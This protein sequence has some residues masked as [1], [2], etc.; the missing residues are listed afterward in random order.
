MNRVAAVATMV[1]G[2][3]VLAE[4][5]ARSAV[6]TQPATEARQLRATQPSTRD[7]TAM[8]SFEIVLAA[9]PHDE[10][11]REGEVQ[12]AVAEALSLRNAG[13]MDEALATLAHARTYVP[14]DPKLLMDFGIQADS[15]RIYRDAEAA[16][17]QAHKLAPNDPKILYGLAHVELDEQKMPQA[18][19]DL[20]AYLKMRPNDASAHYGL[21]HLLH[22]EIRDDEAKLEFK[23]SLDLEP[24]QTESW[25]GLGE[26]ALD[27][28]E[29]AEARADYEKV[30]Q[31]NPT[32]GGAL[33]GM[34]ILAYRAKDYP[35]AEH[36]LSQAVSYAPDFPTAHRFYAMLLT[37]LGRKQQADKEEAYA[38]TL[39]EQQNRLQHGYVLLAKP[40]NR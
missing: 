7:E 21:G 18:E 11:A 19:A 17:V 35:S 38:R 6:P 22:M 1:L 4:A 36:Y 13:Q 31:R 16:L 14:D 30:L 3:A 27:R 29:D 32:H 40:H 23:R 2:L 9:H 12:A 5:Q 10:A 37:R 39:T 24:Q 25:Y 28:H 34:G 20:R 26:I 15:M 8:K 33:T